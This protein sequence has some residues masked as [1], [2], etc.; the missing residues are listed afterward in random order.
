M[1]LR[2]I[3]RRL[4]A[5]SFVLVAGALLAY[6]KLWP[7]RVRAL[8]AGGNGPPD[9]ML[10]RGDDATPVRWR[11]DAWSFGL[12]AGPAE[13]MAPAGPRKSGR[14]CSNVKDTQPES[15]PSRRRSHP[16]RRRRQGA[17]A[18]PTVYRCPTP[19]AVVS[20]P[21]GLL[22]AMSAR[23]RQL[24]KTVCRARGRSPRVAETPA[25]D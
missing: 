1:S 19:A 13:R 6:A 9:V 23:I 17:P 18:L 2:R 15:S 12:P 16:G 20:V 3:D 22:A 5:S 11:P 8:R 7:P 21:G 10:L 14:A 24:T 4:V 25:G